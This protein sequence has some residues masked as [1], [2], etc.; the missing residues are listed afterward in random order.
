MGRR[1]HSIWNELRMGRDNPGIYADTRCICCYRADTCTGTGISS[2]LWPP[3]CRIFPPLAIARIPPPG[4][5]PLELVVPRN[6]KSHTSFD[7]VVN[8][9]TTIARKMYGGVGQHGYLNPP[10]TLCGMRKAI[11]RRS[12]PR[13]CRLP[14]FQGVHGRGLRA[15]HASHFWCAPRWQG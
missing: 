5:I 8:T 15:E 12:T 1:L 7:S 3:R 2:Y 10:G 14:D 6:F 11:P 4:G 9:D 13:A